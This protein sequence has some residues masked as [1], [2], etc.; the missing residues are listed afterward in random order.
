MSAGVTTGRA[1]EVLVLRDGDDVGVAT[2][3]IAPGDTLP[4]VDAAPWSPST[5][6]RAGTRWRCATS[7]GAPG[8]TSTAR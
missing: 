4:G 1:A 7:R 2:R 8:C 6:S 3:D 5:P